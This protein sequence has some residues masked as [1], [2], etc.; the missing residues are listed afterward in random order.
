MQ[1]VCNY[2]IK[3]KN[4]PYRLV[5]DILRTTIGTKIAILLAE[6][7]TSCNKRVSNTNDHT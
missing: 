2:K 7:F 6:M 1:F 5:I 3:M 4:I